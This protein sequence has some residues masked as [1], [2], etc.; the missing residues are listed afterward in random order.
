VGEV[1]SYPNGHFCWVDLGTTD[2]SE[3][4]A[5]YGDLFGWEFQDVPAG[6]SDTYTLCRLGGK[7]VAGIHQHSEEEGS[8]WSSYISVDDVEATTAQARVLGASM[9]VEPQDVPG[10]ARFAVIRDPSR[11]EVALW[12]PQGFA[13]ARLVNEV[14]A[15]AWNELSTPDLDAAKTFYGQLFGWEAFD[16][17]ANIQRIG[18][19]LGDILIAAAHLPRSGEGEAARWTISFMVSDA[20]ESAARAQ[21]LGG[22]IVLPVTEIPIG[23]FAVVADPAGASFMVAA[24]PAFRGLDG[25]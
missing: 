21:E 1:S 10:S 14:G 16:V 11:A 15:W 25:S 12:E 7:D 9:V 19:S 24:A 5:F 4:K 8:R 18:F 2:V 23:K 20:D 17:G 3:A 13:G 22:S 6:G